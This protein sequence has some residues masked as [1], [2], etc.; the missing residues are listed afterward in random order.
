MSNE[1]IDHLGTFSESDWLAAV[2]ELLP[3]VHEVDRNALQIWFRFYPLSLKR[4]VDAGESREETLHGIAM[5]GDFELDGQIATSHH[6]LYGH[7]FWPKVKCVIEKLAEDFKGKPETLTDLIKEVSIVV[8]EKKKVDR[9]L[10]CLLYTSTL[11][12]SDLV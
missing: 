12:T 9:T 10:T 11:P 1:L 4:F 2:E 6:F 3:L 5:Q 7:R 8:A